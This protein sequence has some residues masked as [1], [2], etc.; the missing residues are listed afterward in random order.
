[1]AK[2]RFVIGLIG[3]NGSGKD[4]FTTFFRSV[5]APL[6]IN[7]IRFSDILV[8][9]LTSWNIPLTRANLQKLAIVMDEGYGKGTLTHATAR[10]TK[11]DEADVVIIEGMRWLTD[12]PMV[13]NFKN[14]LIVYVTADSNVRFERLKNRKQKVGEESLT[15]AQFDHEEKEK[16]EIFIPKIGSKAD[17]KIENNGS[18]DEFRDKVEEFFK[19]YI[20]G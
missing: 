12:V 17:F 20:Q 18:L 16:T 5:A 4:T 14:S 2:K 6:K 19:K 1:M 9:T 7:K 11:D 3:E 15:R 8:E 10:R 13:R